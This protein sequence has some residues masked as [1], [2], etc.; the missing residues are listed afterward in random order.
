MTYS[1]YVSTKIGTIGDMTATSVHGGGKTHPGAICP[2]G[3]V[4]FGPDTFE[5]GDNGSGYSYHHTTIDGFSINHMSGVG[6]YG[7]LGNFQVMPTTGPRNLL[8]GTYRDAL[9]TRQDRGYESDFRH[10]TEVTEAGYYAVTLDTYGI[11]AETTVSVHTGMIRMMYPSGVGRRVQI[12]L[13]R[14]IAGRSPLQE[15]QIVDSRTIEGR[16]HCP[17]THGGF[18]RGGGHVNYD[19]Y[20]HAEFSEPWEQYGVWNCNA[21]VDCSEKK[22]YSGEEL[23]FYAEYPAS[24]TPLVLKVGISYIDTEGARGNFAAEAAGKTFDEMHADSTAA[25]EDALSVVKLEGDDNDKLTIFYTTLYHALLDPRVYSDADGRYLSAD[26]SIRSS[27][28]FQKRTVFSGW[29]VFRSEFPLLTIVKPDAVNDIIHSLID[30][31]ENENVSFPRWE[32]LGHET[33]CMLGDPG[34]IVTVDAYRKGIR[35]FD[36]EKAYDICLKTAFDPA[37]KRHG[38]AAMNELGYVP[39]GISDTLENVYAD[40]CISLFAGELGDAETAEQFRKRAFNYRKIFDPSVGWMRRKNA[41][42]SWAEWTD[43]YDERGCTE[44]NIFQQTWFVP[45]DPQGLIA[46]MGQ[47]QFLENLERLMGDSDLSAMWNTAYN[48]PNEPCHHLVHMFTDAG[49]PWR[50]QYWTRRI[51]EEAYN[52]T[53]YGFCGNEDVGQMSAWYALTALGFHM[54]SPGSNIYHINTPLFRRAEIR[55]SKEYHSCAAAE[56][57]VIETDRDP[58]D[59]VYVRGI[60]VNGQPLNRAWLTWDEISGGG[61]IRYELSDEPCTDWA[62]RLPSSLSSGDLV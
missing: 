2:F 43:E 4:Q 40:H 17:S 44:S 35:A 18:G 55:L 47:D 19:L 3:M 60:T 5:G 37:S 20:F 9:T 58:K 8:S 1:S 50:T 38:A 6:W 59:A 28:D 27:D 33:G 34:I 7:D 24:E 52:T 39:G 48:H 12:N 57:L 30:I 62:V 32:L 15:L 25:W 45:H 42:G 14:R 13:A 10:E 53:E 51:Q 22:D 41:D 26:G 31:A 23:W 54:M 49:Q 21:P 11:R 61:V 56:T 46:L 16:I 36:A 29:D